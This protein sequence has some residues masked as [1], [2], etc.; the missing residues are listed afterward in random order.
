MNMRTALDALVFSTGIGN[1]GLFLAC[2][3]FA[4]FFLDPGVHLGSLVALH[5]RVDRSDW[6]Q[7]PRFCGKKDRQRF[8]SQTLDR[9]QI[10]ETTI[11]RTYRKPHPQLSGRRSFSQ[12]PGNVVCLYQVSVTFHHHGV[13]ISQ[14]LGK[15]PLVQPPDRQTPCIYTMDHILHRWGVMSVHGRL[16]TDRIALGSRHSTRAVRSSMLHILILSTPCL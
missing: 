16:S 2:L 15:P 1:F 10:K 4:F 5:L 12:S 14:K 3:V 6:I 9:R 7:P 8:R 11:Y 13:R